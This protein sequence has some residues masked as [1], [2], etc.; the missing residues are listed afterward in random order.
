[1]RET[2]NKSISN[3]PLRRTLREE[4]PMDTTGHMSLAA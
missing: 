2:I 1:M 3:S 4:R